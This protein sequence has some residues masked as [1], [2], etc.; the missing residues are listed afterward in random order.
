MSTH[1][2][3]HTLITLPIQSAIK[4]IELASCIT[5]Q[6]ELFMWEYVGNMLYGIFA[7]YA[8]TPIVNFLDVPVVFI[9]HSGMCPVEC[10]SSPVHS[11]AL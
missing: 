2:P 11:T 3:D 7:Q 6:F 1:L 4:H 5:G 8:R 9:L 10:I